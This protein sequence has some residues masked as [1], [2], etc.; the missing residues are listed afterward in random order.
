MDKSLKI[1]AFV[2][3]LKNLPPGKKILA[4]ILFIFIL[5]AFFFVIVYSVGSVIRGLNYFS[6]EKLSPMEYGLGSGL[7]PSII[8]FVVALGIIIYLL[9]IENIHNE[10]I[11][12]DERGLRFMKDET[13]GGSRWMSKEEIPEVFYVGDIRNTTST[14]Y[15]QLTTG[16]ERV[17]AWK[18]KEKGASG[19]RN[20]IVIAS[21]GSGKTFTYVLNELIQTILRGDS[22]IC[23]D[24]KGECF[25]YLAKFCKEQGADV[26]ILNMGD[27]I[28]RSEF[29]DC[30]EET[31]DP[32]TERLDAG[33]LNDFAT[34]YMENTRNDGENDSFWYQSALNLIKAVIGYIAYIREIEII[35]KF[36]ELYQNIT[37]VTD[38]EFTNRM[39]TKFVSFTWCKQV[40]TKEAVKR[41]YDEDYIRQLLDDIMTKYPSQPYNI[42]AVVD[43]LMDF[44]NVSRDLAKIPAYHPA[45]ISY[46]MYMTND[47][48]SVRK[49]ALQG[50]QMRFSLFN[51]SNLRN[52]LSYPGI[53][54]RDLNKKQTA[55]FVI[56]SD[57]TT[58]TKPF[59]SLFTSF[60]FKDAMET[61]DENE[62][63]SASEGKD[64]PTLGV[65]VMLEEFFSIGVIGG[66]P[67]TFGMYMSTAR[68]RK[69]YIK[70]IIQYIAQLEALYGRNIKHAVQ[71]GCSTMIYLGGNDEETCEFI[72]FFAGD[73]TI[74]GESHRE[75]GRRI[76]GT[77][78]GEEDS[79][80]VAS[81]TRRLITPDDARRWKER[82]LIIKQGEY[83][84]PINPFPISDHWVCRDGLIELTE[85][86]RIAQSSQTTFFEFITPVQERVDE[87]DAIHFEEGSDVQTLITKKIR[88][89]ND[90]KGVVKQ[91]ESKPAEVEMPSK[92][93][94]DV[95]DNM[96]DVEELEEVSF[97][98]LQEKLE[99][100]KNTPVKE[101]ETQII[102]EELEPIP[103]QDPVPIPVKPAVQNEEFEKESSIQ[104]DVEE[105]PV[106]NEKVSPE[107]PAVVSEPVIKESPKNEK[108]KIEE[109]QKEEP[110]EEK[111]PIK[112]AV[113]FT[114]STKQTTSARDTY[115]PK[116]DDDSPV[117]YK[118]VKAHSGRG[119]KKSKPVT[120]S[121]LGDD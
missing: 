36:K 119:K 28:E 46:Q 96:I 44:E 33:R 101:P 16:G 113:D 102:R 18:K 1:K 70:V 47:S 32:K 86:G 99:V 49:S 64:N 111:K 100:L 43:T 72:S 26:H 41:G 61:F 109:K 114:A 117:K 52:V 37:G 94:I 76:L 50:A 75:S 31:I 93:K 121:V 65:T 27:H 68:S 82:T 34:I 24:P 4:G 59:V 79:T 92:K 95:F 118:P 69:L 89:V 55:M 45:A 71:G 66:D 103:E 29:W 20:D 97:E 88:N 38:D 85:S 115:G 104:Q 19:N 13:G 23:T 51:D 30:L 7:G 91:V 110:K 5:I 9:V 78:K 67:K 74:L 98:F 77:K 39:E 42:G 62:Q 116:R 22:F 73:A 15:G 2:D 80:N 87:I 81:K 108:E 120:I 25:L 90:Y 107:T 12:I 48:D 84:L 56:M 54:I 11:A 106:E 40:I 14:I 21:M 17:V 83:P 6:E 3:R 8:V 105:R 10:V 35:S 58:T 60:F 57:K 53:H 63:I 112:P